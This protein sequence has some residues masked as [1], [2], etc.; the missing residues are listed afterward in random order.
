MYLNPDYSQ[1]R[2]SL[3]DC[4][5]NIIRYNDFLFTVRH[6][7]MSESNHYQ[8]GRHFLQIPGPSN[9]PDRVLRAMAQP[10]IDHRSSEFAEMCLPIL[11]KLKTADLEAQVRVDKVRARLETMP[12]SSWLS[13]KTSGMSL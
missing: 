10:T 6:I 5:D 4:A 13:A 1:C 2:I 8:A 3:T 12:A 9:V 11:E 7:I